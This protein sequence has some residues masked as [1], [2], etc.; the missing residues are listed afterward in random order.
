[1]LLFCC[2]RVHPPLHSFPTRRSSDLEVLGT[3]LRR[4]PVAPV[5]LALALRQRQV[6]ERLSGALERARRAGTLTQVELAPLSRLEA[7]ELLG[8]A[9]G[10]ALATDL[11]IESG[12][13]PFYLEQLARSFARGG[14]GGVA[15]GD[16]QLTGVE[17]P[18]VVAAAL[19]GELAL[20]SESARHVLEGAAVAGDPFEPEL[21]AAAAA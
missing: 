18:E 15:L 6:P 13:N 20:L 7:V 16:V 2:Y 17:V 21:A 19:T 10:G 1:L 4:P 8:G 3:L 12:G 9:L 11:Y 5:L 14:D